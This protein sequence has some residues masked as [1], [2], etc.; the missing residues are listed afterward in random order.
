MARLG[1]LQARIAMRLRGAPVDD[2]LQ[3]TAIILDHFGYDRAVQLAAPGTVVPRDAI[4]RIARIIEAVGKGVPVHRAI[5]TRSFHG[6]ELAIGAETL[7]PRDDTGTLVEAALARLMPVERPWRIADLGT[8]TGAVGLALLAERP[9]ATLV[10]TDIAPGALA[11]ARDNAQRHALGGRTVLRRGSW[12]EP[13]G[14]DRFDAIVSNPP[15]IAS[16][17]VDTLHPS[18]RDHDPRAALDGGADGLDAY[19]AILR[20][21]A[22]H[23]LPC[24]FLALETGFDQRD[25][26]ASLAA[27]EGW[28][29]LEQ[30]RDL[31]GRDR[32]T[33]LERAGKAVRAAK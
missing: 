31:G 4:A 26:L 22:R 19:R 24:G 33:V 16:A 15:Y 27:R 11:V 13:L 17:I 30:R 2:P 8:G 12:L 18:V 21:A 29:V 23:L 3:I 6:L 28:C 9:A 5:G 20:G 25:A 10:A 1:D 14:T 32:V 7:E